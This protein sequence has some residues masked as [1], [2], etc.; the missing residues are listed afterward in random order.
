MLI[1]CEAGEVKFCD[2]KLTLLIVERR[3][4][5]REC[6]EKRVGFAVVVCVAVADA[7]DIVEKFNDS[8]ETMS[9]LADNLLEAGWCGPP[10]KGPFSTD[11]GPSA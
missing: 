4:A 6:I 1:E 8:V 10:R 11:T 7:N 3:I 5:L 9:N 2:A